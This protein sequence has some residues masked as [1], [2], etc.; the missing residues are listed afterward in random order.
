MYEFTPIVNDLSGI[1]NVSSRL[2]KLSNYAFKQFVYDIKELRTR[3][4]F[5][6]ELSKSAY[7]HV[8]GFLKITLAKGS[9]GSKLRLHIWNDTILEYSNAQL[10]AHNHPWSFCS[11]VL[12]GSFRN[13]IY[14]TENTAG[15]LHHKHSCI[16]DGPE[17]YGHTI[18]EEGAVKLMETSN[19]VMRKGSSY[20]EYSKAIH[21]AMPE[22]NKGITSTLI[23]Q[24]PPTG[25][26]SDLYL[27]YPLGESVKNKIANKRMI[28]SSIDS[29]FCE[30]KN[31]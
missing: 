1:D 29:V 16:I 28:E 18:K 9:D 11:V 2:S 7:F 20:F 26:K 24:Y 27:L 15:E 23:Y 10:S 6:E 17:N 21:R 25:N 4:V 13:I 12:C 14:Q 3:S 19:T 5:L 31:G 8:N 22:N 30:I